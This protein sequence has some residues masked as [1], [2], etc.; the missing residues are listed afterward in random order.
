MAFI[1]V[2]CC[3]SLPSAASAAGNISDTDKY[4]W[5]ETAGW[6]NFK[7]THGGVTVNSDHLSGYVWAES[8][9]WIK[10][11]VDAGGPYGNTN[12]S[13]WGV[14]RD[15]S[16]NLSG[17]GWSEVAGWVN[18]NPTDNQV[19]IDPAT[20]DFDGYAWC[21]GV[22]YIHLQNDAPAYK[23]QLFI[24]GDGDGVADSQDTCEGGNDNDDADSDGVP[25]FCDNCITD[26]N[27]DQAD[28]TNPPDGIGNVCDDGD[29]DGDGITD[30][31]EA[32]CGSDP[33]D[34]DSRCGSL[35]WL[36]L[37]LDD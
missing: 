33:S 20:G 27:P 1:T 26:A 14:N 19:V 4:A 3:L 25:D 32:L 36:L 5:S 11:G 21:E 10:M 6:F 17:Y 2:C 18:F 12:A 29:A 34:T 35:S 13:D 16:G 22:G 37:L 9:G 23:V 31:A 24:D 15:G 28:A 7:P 30:M 8:I